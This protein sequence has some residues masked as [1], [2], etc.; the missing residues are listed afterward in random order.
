MIDPGDFELSGTNPLQPGQHASLQ[1]THQ[2]LRSVRRVALI[3]VVILRGRG[4][5]EDPYREVTMLFDDEGRCIA[6]HDPAFPTPWYAP[7]EACR[8]A[9]T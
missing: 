1:K 3:E 7:V 8:E 4:T 5:E 6:E 2:P 9:R